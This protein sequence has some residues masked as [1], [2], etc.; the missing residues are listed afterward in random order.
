MTER[1]STLDEIL[2]ARRC[3]SSNIETRSPALDVVAAAVKMASIDATSANWVRT[4]EQIDGGSFRRPRA[5]RSQDDAENLLLELEVAR[6]RPSSRRILWTK[7]HYEL[8][9]FED[10][11][12]KMSDAFLVNI[13]QRHGFTNVF[14]RFPRFT[15]IQKSTA[16]TIKLVQ[17]ASEEARVYEFDKDTYR[18]PPVFKPAAV[19]NSD[20]KLP[21]DD[22]NFSPGLESTVRDYSKAGR[23]ISTRLVDFLE[24]KMIDLDQPGPVRDHTYGLYSTQEH[25]ENGVTTKYPKMRSNSA[26]LIVARKARQSGW[27][28]DDE[29]AGWFIIAV[30]GRRK[31]RD[32]YDRLSRDDPRFESNK[33]HEAWLQTIIEVVVALVGHQ[34]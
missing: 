27:T 12:E 1:L 25:T 7:L 6:A 5:V 26:F 8:N 31:L 13:A 10:L 14:A 2:K 28:M 18:A 11:P 19:G 9:R 22:T 20:A 4:L 15:R 16:Q 3:F 29:V 33:S 32:W 21:K 23:D 34:A 17:L 24:E 30:E